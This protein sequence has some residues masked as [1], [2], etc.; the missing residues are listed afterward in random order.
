VTLNATESGELLAFAAM[1]HRQRTLLRRSEGA[2]SEED[3]DTTDIDTLVCVLGGPKGHAYEVEV[4]PQSNYESVT[5]QIT[6]LAYTPLSQADATYVARMQHFGSE[7]LDAS[8]TVILNGLHWAVESPLA[9]FLVETDNSPAVLKDASASSMDAVPIRYAAQKADR[10][11]MLSEQQEVVQYAGSTPEGF[12]L[13]YKGSEQEVIVRSLAEHALCVH[14]KAPLVKDT[15]HVILCPMPGTLISLKA[16]VGQSVVEGQEVAVI[17][18]MK[19]QNVL[20]SPKDGVI[21]AVNCVVG[22]HL[23]VDQVIVEFEAVTAE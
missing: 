22:S 16:A 18:A 17:E 19:M 6:P 7:P 21:K 14:M 10:K 5:C 11:E 12:L 1:L 23:R 9:A 2:D 20:R 15:S 8:S 4:S 13:R 3:I